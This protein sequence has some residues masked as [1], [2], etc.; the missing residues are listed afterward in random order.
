MLFLSSVTEAVL[1][2]IPIRSLKSLKNV[3][4]APKMMLTPATLSVFTFPL[5]NPAVTFNDC[6]LLNRYCKL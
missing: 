6:V 5:R 1:N 3:A 2:L 4:S